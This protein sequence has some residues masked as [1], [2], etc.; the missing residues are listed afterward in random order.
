MR[1][2]S[3]NS[4][5]VSRFREELHNGYH[6]KKSLVAFSSSLRIYFVLF[7]VLVSECEEEAHLALYI[8]VG[9]PQNRAFTVIEIK[10]NFSV[11]DS[12]E[13]PEAIQQ[14]TT[15]DTQNR[16]LNQTYVQ[17]KVDCVTFFNPH[18][19]AIEFKCAGPFKTGPQNKFKTLHALAG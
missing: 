12:P 7:V 16:R 4:A 15:D 6:R 11:N 13:L 19:V 8:R 5:R 10:I 3:Q 2:S 18:S 1:G 14:T 9:E 17:Q